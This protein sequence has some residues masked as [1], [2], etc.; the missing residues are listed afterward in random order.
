MTQRRSRLPGWMPGATSARGSSEGQVGPASMR[1]RVPS[2]LLRP[3]A[4]PLALG[5]VVA[6]LLIAAE[7]FLVY[8]LKLAAPGNIFGVILLLGVLVVATLW[9][10]RLGAVTSLASAVVYVCFHQLQTGRSILATWAQNWMAVTV[11]LVVALS[12]AT[13]AG[14]AR[15]RAAEADL[16]RRQVEAS[17]GELSVLAEQQA[18]LRRVAMLVARG[19]TQPEI[20]AAVADA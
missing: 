12:A 14:L 17:H 4:P 9:G 1:A 20:F 6:A 8:L 11:F 7:S 16:R 10:F 15:S 19:A 13:I 18:A 5:L 3:T 2:L